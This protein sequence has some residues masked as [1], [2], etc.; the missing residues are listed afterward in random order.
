MARSME[1]LRSSWDG[2]R[3]PDLAAFVTWV[4]EKLMPNIDYFVDTLSAYPATNF[5]KRKLMY[6]NWHASCADC[7][8]AIGLLSDDRPRYN[9]GLQLYRTT[10]ESY[11]KWGKGEYAGGRM[12]GEST[13]TLRDI[14]HTL[15]G[16]GSLMQAAETAWGQNEDAYSAGDYVLASGLELH[17][18]IINAHLDKDESGLP[19]KF[20]FFE[21]MPPP[22][23]RCAWRWSVKTQGWSS[24]R[25]DGSK[26]SDLDDGFKYALGIK[27]LP[28]G[29]ELGYNHFVG[30][31]GMKLP[32]TAR[33]LSRYPVDYYE[34]C[35]VS[36]YACDR[37][38]ACVA[39]PLSCS[40]G[41][42]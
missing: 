29:F 5:D 34:F 15:F 19:P 23:A 28:T 1:V 16:I 25:G 41:D 7:M 14:Y 38:G 17:A 37:I 2:L 12:V 27:Y 42:V 40:R 21:S 31:L 30:R 11:F 4:N 3:Q 32:E 13:E 20:R 22:P 24:Y 6:G 33:L 26:C 9:K 8:M 10:V 35:W 18:R 39:R 36:V